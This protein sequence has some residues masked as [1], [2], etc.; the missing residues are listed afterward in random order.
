MNLDLRPYIAIWIVFA[1]GVAVLLVRRR[2]V[3][4]KE[5]DNLHVMSG[6]NPEQVLIAAKLD[7]IDK[8]GKLLTV[9]TVLLGLII[10]GLYIY[11][12]FVGKPSIGE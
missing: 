3:A 5:D 8:W 12:T 9:I 2:L 10:A 7:V 11:S 1:L 6:P 4:S